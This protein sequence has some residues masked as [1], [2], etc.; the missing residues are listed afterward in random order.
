MDKKTFCFYF[1]IDNSSRLLK[2]M[3]P[4]VT[5]TNWT[6]F[7]TILGLEDIM[8]LHHTLPASFKSEWRL[9]FSNTLYGDSFT[10][11]VSHIVKKGPNLLVI[12]DKDGYVFGG[13]N[14]EGWEINSKFSGKLFCEIYHIPVFL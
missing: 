10:Q 3:I 1:Q 11:L 14:N 7:N 5:D 6:K 9:L 4:V 13:F 12:R 8:Y 2:P